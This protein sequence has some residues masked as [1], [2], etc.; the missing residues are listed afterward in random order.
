MNSANTEADKDRLGTIIA[1]FVALADIDRETL[2]KLYVLKDDLAKGL[3]HF[4]ENRFARAF[5]N[6]EVEG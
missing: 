2:T 6:C 5:K 3:P 4:W 1:N